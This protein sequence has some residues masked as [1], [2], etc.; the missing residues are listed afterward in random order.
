MPDG[1]SPGLG[2]RN[3]ARG[4]CEGSQEPRIWLR[5]LSL[6]GGW[7][8]AVPPGAQRQRVCMGVPPGRLQREQQQDVEPAKTAAEGGRPPVRHRLQKPPSEDEITT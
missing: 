1:G 2:W 4:G 8:R 7:G 3:T 6:W 5:S